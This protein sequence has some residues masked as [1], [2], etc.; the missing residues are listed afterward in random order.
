MIRIILLLEMPKLG[1]YL[2]NRFLQLLRVFFANVLSYLQETISLE[3]LLEQL[4]HRHGTLWIGCM[5]HI[6]CISALVG[7]PF[8]SLSASAE[9]PAA[10]T[11]SIHALVAFFHASSAVLKSG[12]F[13]SIL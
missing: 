10:T 6:L 1:V 4:L 5:R 9:P 3:R 7:E 11:T 12:A 8:H 2:P 13:R